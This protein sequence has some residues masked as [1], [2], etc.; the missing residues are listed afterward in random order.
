MAKICKACQRGTMES[1]I[2][3][4]RCGSELRPMPKCKCGN[5]LWPDV[6]FCT[7]CGKSRNEALK[8]DEPNNAT[9]PKSRWQRFCTWVRRCFSPHP[10]NKQLP[11]GTL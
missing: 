5:E 11:K 2:F 10:N 3:C 4:E 8:R 1:Y 6:L 9:L 7:Q